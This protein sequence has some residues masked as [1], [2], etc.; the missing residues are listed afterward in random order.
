ML[1]GMMNDPRRDVV[2]EARW[3]AESGFDFLDL[4]LEAPAALPE[5]IAARELREVCAQTGLG[6]VGHTAW[7]LPFGSPAARVREAAVAEVA[8][9]FELLAALGA[10]RCNVHINAFSAGVIAAADVLRWN[11]ESFARLAELAQPYG[12]SVMV[13]HVPGSFNS[14]EAIGAVLAADARL[15]F[16][17]DVGHA[18]LDGPDKT[19]A[20]L[21]AFGPRLR[22]VHLA[23]N[24]LRTDDHMP[25]GAG[26]VDWPAVVRLLRA[27]GY[28]DTLTL[29]VF[30]SDRAYLVASAERWRSWWAAAVAA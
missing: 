12:L 11:G 7:Y 2:A 4:T 28:D 21:E 13:E 30:T 8:A 6:L 22:H 10:D 15:G 3:A 27:A 29:E 19:A 9:G 5:A 16:H 18:H 17:L 25:L 24:K 1:V 20:L 14:V 23:D 26:W